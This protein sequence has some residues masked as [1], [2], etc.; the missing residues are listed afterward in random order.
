MD[1]SKNRLINSVLSPN[2]LFRSIYP[3]NSVKDQG[4]SSMFPISTLA[5]I[6]SKTPPFLS[7]L[8]ERLFHTKS[9]EEAL[10]I[11]FDTAK[12]S[13]SS[14]S[15]PQFVKKDLTVFTF[16]PYEIIYTLPMY[17][18]NDVNALHKA[19]LLDSKIVPEPV[20]HIHN[21]PEYS[22]IVNRYSGDWKKGDSLLPF[23]QV[24]V[25]NNEIQKFFQQMKTL[26]QAGIL[27]PDACKSENYWSVNSAT[28]EL[29]VPLWQQIRPAKEP[30]QAVEC[31]D[32]LTEL[33]QKV[34][35]RSS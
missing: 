19:K 35:S 34:L 1:Y 13:E 2:L 24:K 29:V 28:D 11:L 32:N 22:I 10:T 33:C 3:D 20:L 27:L 25:S 9:S 26:I 30:S 8:L 5:D 4:Q 15:F 23:K 16:G 12:Q 14:D 7:A 18:E 31:L 21:S 6:Q 17:S